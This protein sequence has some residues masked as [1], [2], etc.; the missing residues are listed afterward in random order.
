MTIEHTMRR[1]KEN[2]FGSL[3]Q[4]PRPRSTVDYQKYIIFSPGRAGSTLVTSWLSEHPEV[5]SGAEI[6]GD[7]ALARRCMLEPLQQ[8][9]GAA[10][11]ALLRRYL[12]NWPWG[13]RPAGI[14][15][16][17]F[18]LIYSQF[19]AQR[20]TI[21]AVLERE[22][23]VKFIVV[24]RRN[25]LERIISARRIAHS[26]IENVKADAARPEERPLRLDPNECRETF[27][28]MEGARVFAWQVVRNRPHIWL[29]YE[30]I[31]AD[32]AAAAH[33]ICDFLGVQRLE[34]PD[35]TRKLAR[36]TP[37]EGVTNYEELRQFFGGTQWATLFA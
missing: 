6:L 17:G 33:R 30:D 16:A 25:L 3:R 2:I 12:R 10:K 18:K 13:R 21:N 22:G 36:Q 37:A 24:E 1:H 9:E 11:E 29:D 4:L 27:M 5:V 15:A 31:V 19:T 26:G 32:K 35:G 7:A 20:E 8:G 28:K 23:E 14:K 34:L